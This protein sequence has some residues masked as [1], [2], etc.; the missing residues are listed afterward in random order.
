MIIHVYQKEIIILE[1]PVKKKF[2]LI[3]IFQSKY[4]FHYSLFTLHF[5]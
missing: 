2:K 4:T 5:K 3:I 1:I